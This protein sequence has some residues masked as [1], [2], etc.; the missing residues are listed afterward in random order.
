MNCLDYSDVLLA[1]FVLINFM[2]A[3]QEKL[4]LQDIIKWLKTH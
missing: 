3:D 4:R 2:N 1:H